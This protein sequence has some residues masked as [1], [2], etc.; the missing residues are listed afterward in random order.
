MD[1]AF[2]TD[3]KSGPEIGCNNVGR[4]PRRRIMAEYLFGRKSV[5]LFTLCG[6]NI[7]FFHT[8]VEKGKF[9]SACK[10]HI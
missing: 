8:E 10:S 3:Y 5:K 7:F 6:D 4:N 2:F 9:L 1:N